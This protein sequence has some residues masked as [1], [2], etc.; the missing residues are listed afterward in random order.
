MYID[1]ESTT[2]QRCNYC[3][4]FE[5]LNDNGLCEFCENDSEVLAD[6]AESDQRLKEFNR[7][8]RNQLNTI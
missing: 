6:I 4:K 5:D 8:Y 1:P 3:G 2:L 7:Y